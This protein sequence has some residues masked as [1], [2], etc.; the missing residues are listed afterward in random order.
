[1][2]SSYERNKH[3]QELFLQTGQIHRFDSNEGYGRSPNLL[4]IYQYVSC[5]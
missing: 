4:K 5:K 2:S 1:M 3:L